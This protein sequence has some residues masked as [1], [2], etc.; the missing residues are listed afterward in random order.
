V[1]SYCFF[2]IYARGED[3]FCDKSDLPRKEKKASLLD[4]SRLVFEL[5]VPSSRAG[6]KGGTRGHRTPQ[7]EVGRADV[8]LVF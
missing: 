6:Q 5:A 3:I 1:Q 8:R 4:G 2:L 7:T